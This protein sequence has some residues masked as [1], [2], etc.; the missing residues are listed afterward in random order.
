MTSE[1]SHTHKPYKS[2]YYARKSEITSLQRE[3]D[4]L[5]RRLA[6]LQDEQ[7]EPL[8]SA[9]RVREENATM[10][11]SLTEGDLV[12]AR[13]HSVLLGEVATH[14]RNPLDMN[15]RLSADPVDRQRTLDALVE[16][17]LDNSIQLL[18][19]RIKYMNLEQSH[20]QIQSFSTLE[21]D[22]MLV[23]CDVTAF[24]DVESVEQVHQ[25]L[26]LALSHREF[27][28]WEH[29]GVSTISDIEGDQRRPACLARYL[30]SVP[31]G[32]D[33]E[34]NMA[35][36]QRYV[37][38]SAYL[39]EPHGVI[40]VESIKEDALYPYQPQSRVRV[41][42]SAVVLVVERPRPLGNQSDSI[43]VSLFRW[44]FTRLHRPQFPV[45]PAIKQELLDI[46]P[47]WGE[48]LRK[49]MREYVEAR[50][51]QPK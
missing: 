37:E 36:F 40:I 2:T 28:F 50:R 39:N 27:Q 26:Q 4:E 30:S 20:R 1:A 23:Q 29:L 8:K 13:A 12:V 43:D 32:V 44:S 17:K 6:R 47:R 31:S 49:I 34:V 7:P 3:I 38:S 19:E 22:L 51:R 5:T 11:H 45:T 35:Q 33:I 25:D 15:I 41:D 18:L 42:P 46:Y 10:Q 21:G 48:A 9:Q 16:T 24:N 14:A